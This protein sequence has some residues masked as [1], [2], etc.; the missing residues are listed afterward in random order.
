MTAGHHALIVDDDRATADDLAEILKSLGC[1][2]TIA[3]NKHDALSALGGV[4]YCLILLDLQ[5]KLEL[6]SIKGHTEHGNSLLR[7]IRQLHSDHTGLGFWLPIIIVS[8]FAREVSAAVEAMKDGANDV[9]HKPFVGR[10]VSETIRQALARSG[11]ATHVLCVAGPPTRAVDA[12]NATLLSIPGD[13]V[14]RRTR[15]MVG[16]RSTFLTDSSLKVLLHLM[17]AHAGRTAVHKRDLGAS[18]DQG[19]KGISVLRDA[20]RP[21]LGEGI[22]IIHND[23][24]G[25]YHLTNDVTISIFDGEKL[26]SIGDTKITELARELRRVLDSTSS[27]V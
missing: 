6:G 27:E 21:A 18:K 20:L 5:I 4:T 24:H 10:E 1:D 3:T 13:R 23:H 12:G 16:S 2:C 8:G 9:I 15:V 17:V 7:E 19:F 22:E 11:R 14:G 25:N 26:A